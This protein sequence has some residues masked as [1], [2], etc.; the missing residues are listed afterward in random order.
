M[1]NVLVS[2]Y[3]HFPTRPGACDVTDTSVANRMRKLSRQNVYRDM[4]DIYGR[5]AEAD[6]PYYTMPSTTI[7]NEQTEFARWLYSDGSPGVC[8]DGNMGACGQRI[9]HHYPGI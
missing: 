7:P 2:D 8:R 1:M 9:Y 4:D 3:G 5:K 6:R